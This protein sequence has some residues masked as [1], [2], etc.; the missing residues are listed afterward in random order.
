MVRIDSRWSIALSVLSVSGF[1]LGSACSLDRA[2]LALVE[3]ST[4]SGGNPGPPSRAQSTESAGGVQGARGGISGSG[5]NSGGSAGMA[6]GGASGAAGSAPGAAIDAGSKAGS[7]DDG[8]AGG[9]APC[10]SFPSA[11]PFVTPTDRLAHCYWVHADRLDWDSSEKTCSNEG[12]TLATILS[13]EENAFVL[14]LSLKGGLFQMPPTM[15]ST[16]G[17]SLGATDGRMSSDRSGPGPYS[18]VTGEPRSY[19]NWHPSQPDGSCDCGWSGADCTCDHWLAM[20]PDG[21]WYDRPEA[22]GRSFVCEAVAR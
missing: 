7:S 16:V 9:G 19:A 8:A 18:W 20:G 12:G 17:I 3:V 14:G 4:S 22:A 11:V 2:G 6:M 13:A 5:G 10:S 15:S 1:W 21:S